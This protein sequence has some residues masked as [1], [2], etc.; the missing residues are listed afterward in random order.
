MILLNKCPKYFELNLNSSDA[1]YARSTTSNWACVFASNG[2]GSWN[3]ARNQAHISAQSW[4]LK[5]D[6]KPGL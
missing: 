3:H 4:I 1:P 5:S 6:P 2:E